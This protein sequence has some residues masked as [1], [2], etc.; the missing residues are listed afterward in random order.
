MKSMKRGKRALR[1]L[2]AAATGI[3]LLLLAGR[4]WLRSLFGKTRFLDQTGVI[5]SSEALEQAEAQY[6]L[7]G[8]RPATEEELEGTW[9]LLVIG[10]SAAAEEEKEGR[11]DA[12][13]VITMTV[14]RNT[15]EL[16]LYSFHTDLYVKM[17]GNGGGRLGGAYAAGGGPLLMKTIEENYGIK[18]NNYAAIS[19]RDVARE[20]G[21]LEFETLDI[22]RDGLAVVRELVFSL[23]ADSPVQILSYVSKLLP[24]VTH[25]MTEKELMRILLQVPSI[26]PYY[27]VEG[28]VPGTHKVQ[29]LDG[30]LVPEA[31]E[32]SE[33]LK[34]VIYAKQAGT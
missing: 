23:N 20:I 9:T 25:N 3:L 30:C 12:D 27:G 1:L 14:N 22:S 34:R 24:F 19:L 21:M 5:Q 33:S 32:L 4:I 15:Q 10:G 8:V 28:M 7:S 17:P 18:V 2:L 6:D 26:I 13:A 29:E 31:G 16:I 11:Q